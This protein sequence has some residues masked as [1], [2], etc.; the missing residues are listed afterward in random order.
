LTRAHER[1]A[2]SS[3]VV[4]G[5]DCGAAAVRT[6]D[7]TPSGW[8][9]RQVASKRFRSPPEGL[10]LYREILSTLLCPARTVK[11]YYVHSPSLLPLWSSNNYSNMRELQILT[12]RAIESLIAKGDILVIADNNV[13]RL[14][15]WRDKHPGGEL[16]LRHMIGRDAT[17]EMKM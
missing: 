11:S 17:D 16:V 12:R 8:G 13:L 9:L 15:G 2:S 6:R 5:H 1:A 14:N 3:L 10:E 7:R 4:V